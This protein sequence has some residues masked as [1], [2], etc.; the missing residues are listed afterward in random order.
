MT[1][2]PTA[3][4]GGISSTAASGTASTLRSPSDPGLTAN[5]L[6]AQTPG[7]Q[8]GAESQAVNSSSTSVSNGAARGT[9]EGPVTARGRRTRER[10]IDAAR[11][12]FEE[13]GFSDTRMSDIAERAGVSHGT[14]YVYFD[15][16][17]AILHAVV[18]ALLV[19]LG[20]YLRANGNDDPVRRISE[21]NLRYLE[22]Y[23]RHARLL[24]VVEQ[25]ATSD[26]GFAEILSD[27]RAKHVAR[28]ADGIRKLQQDR[29]VDPRLD[30]GVSAAALSAMVEGYA[31][32]S[33]GYQVED[34]HPTL[35]FLW[36]RALGLSDP[37][38]AAHTHTPTRTS[39]TNADTGAA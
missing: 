10:V 30:A 11:V 33:P 20:K 8:A 7:T 17:Q 36:L 29:Q 35:T 39:D 4:S 37:P 13:R 23:T 9:G 26:P 24:Q 15:S 1:V 34:V 21:A 31:R 27:F 16:K 14:I 32:H 12:V 22:V 28:V 6:R 19:D 18:A 38:G 25:V 2:P 3:S 5:G